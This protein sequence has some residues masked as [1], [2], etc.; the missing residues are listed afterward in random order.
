MRSRNIKPGFFKNDELAEI[1]P[2]GRILFIGLWCLADRDGRL[3]SRSKKIKAEVLPYD[4]CN[5][6]KLLRDLEAKNFIIQYSV[7][8]CNYIQ[9]NNFQKHQHPHIKEAESTIPAPDLHQID[10][11]RKRLIPDSLLLIPD[12][13]DSGSPPVPKPVS[14]N[15]KPQ[16]TY[17]PENFSISPEVVS[18]AEKK[19]FDRLDDHFEFFK[20]S[21]IA[22]AYQYVDWDAAFKNAIRNDWA[23]IR[24]NAPP[25]EP[26]EPKTYK[27]LPD[28]PQC[29]G[30]GY[31]QKPSKDG[32]GR[33]VA[34]KCGCIHEQIERDRLQTDNQERQNTQRRANSPGVNPA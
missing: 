7:N 15:S 6:T 1:D 12:I 25:R 20:D 23:R 24:A 34:T 4:T 2:L 10:M 31:C 8:G 3:E 17:L 33:I 29:H 22:K 30:K 21:S 26:P 11:V 19:G 18:W 13:P 9:I 14:K 27:P 16:K 5:I 28:C 32:T